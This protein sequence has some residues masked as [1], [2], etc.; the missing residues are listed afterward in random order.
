M[1]CQLGSWIKDQDYTRII[2]A[3]L[4]QNENLYVLPSY[5]AVGLLI[6]YFNKDKSNDFLDFC[7]TDAMLDKII[8][9]FILTDIPLSAHSDLTT[10]NRSNL[11]QDLQKLKVQVEFEK[12]FLMKFEQ[13][14]IHLFGFADKVKEIEDKIEEIK[15]KHASNTMKIPLESNQVKTKY[16]FVSM[17][18]KYK[19]EK[20]L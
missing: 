18:R 3:Y 10:T 6:T 15:R 1:Y 14:C 17:S 19:K 2:E 8:K 5:E 4:N 13:R 7:T 12:F 9:K 20:F 11:A 16:S